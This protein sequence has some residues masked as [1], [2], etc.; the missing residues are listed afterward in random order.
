MWLPD[1][2]YKT[3]P[4]IY[5]VAGLLAIYHA[6]NL[7]GQGSGVLLILTAFLVW[8]LRKDGGAN[9]KSRSHAKQ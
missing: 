8:K 6:G 9:N 5:M 7:I 3:L 4:L 2:L 1:W